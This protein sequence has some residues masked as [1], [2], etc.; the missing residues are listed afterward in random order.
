MRH[1]FCS[2]PSL[3]PAS[4]PAD[5]VGGPLVIAA[6]A[7]QQEYETTPH[8]H[9]R[10]QLTLTTAG[11]VVLHLPHEVIVAF[12]GHSIWV[13][14]RRL[15]SVHCYGPRD[16]LCL[17]VDESAC[18][19]LS[20]YSEVIPT[21]AL[22][23]EAALRV[24]TWGERDEALEASDQRVAAILIGEIRFFLPVRAFT[25][26]IP[27]DPRLRKVTQALIECPT[28]D[29]DLHGWSQLAGTNARTLSR[30]FSAD[31]GLTF[32]EWRQRARLLRSL[33]LLT[34]EAPISDIARQ[35][36]YSTAS[37]FSSVFRAILGQTPAAFR[38][39]VLH[40]EISN[41]HPAD[42]WLVQ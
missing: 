39:L 42:S 38:K 12:P 6:T 25:L 34:T 8:S 20:R 24:A 41:C 37:A 35:L 9:S 16:P 22:L 13:P 26:T 27:Y 17:Y 21:S 10:G 4:Q 18:A 3:S 14:A 28:S 36:G 31:T 29:L 2:P 33:E 23:R 5:K 15:H 11:V 1:D 7:H 19:P 40:P 32:V 30:R